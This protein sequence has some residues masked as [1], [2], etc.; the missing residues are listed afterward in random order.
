MIL[1]SRSQIAQ[2]LAPLATTLQVLY[3]DPGSDSFSFIIL[4]TNTY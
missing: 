3:F 4:S 2:R 1:S